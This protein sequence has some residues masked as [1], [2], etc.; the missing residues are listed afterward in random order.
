M[1]Y[2]L[3]V[4]SLLYSRSTIFSR[5]TVKIKY[6]FISRKIIRPHS[7][8]LGSQTNPT[9]TKLWCW[10]ESHRTAIMNCWCSSKKL[11]KE[12]YLNH[13]KWPT[14][15][16]KAKI[17]DGSCPYVQFNSVSVNDL[18]FNTVL[19]RR[20]HR[21]RMFSLKHT[22]KI[23]QNFPAGREEGQGKQTNKL[24][25]WFVKR[26]AAVSRIFFSERNLQ[27]MHQ[28]SSSEPSWKLFCT[29][30]RIAVICRITQWWLVIARFVAAFSCVCHIIPGIT[31]KLTFTTDI[32]RYLSVNCLVDQAL[33]QVAILAYCSVAPSSP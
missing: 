9:C 6:Q 27:G 23:R 3:R 16:Y 30:P 2:Q 31:M 20:D 25:W 22:S 28:M 14:H 8:N 32:F 33:T 7:T 29:A 18:L 19:G 17:C 4:P 24:T 12:V 10:C 5:K 1:H 21:F 26:T 13:I 15:Q 11:L